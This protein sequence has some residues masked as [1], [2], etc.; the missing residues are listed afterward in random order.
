MPLLKTNG[1]DIAYDILGSGEPLL[2]IGGFG[3]TREFWGTL[4]AALA[5]RF[6][7][8]VYD[9]RGSGESTLP[10]E[11]FSI[12]DM[13]EDAAGIMDFLDIDSA[14][15]FGVS[16]GGMIAQMLCARHPDR[17]RKAILGC[18]SHGGRHAIPA[19]PLT[20]KAFEAVA[21]PGLTVEAS[22]RMLVPILFSDRFVESEKERVESY[23]RVSVEHAL[24]RQCAIFQMEALMGFDAEGLLEQIR[25]P[26]LVV[27]GSEDR[28]IPPENSR[29]LAGKIPNARLE[30]ISDAGHNFFFETPETVRSLIE[31]FLAGLTLIDSMA[32]S[33]NASLTTP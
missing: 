1:I 12:A 20:V 10:A 11:P 6:R 21:N 29:L 22:A 7:V 33:P 17:V 4:P 8:I 28:L 5:E 30:V 13:A 16:M 27:T 2:L 9:N 3:M 24:T 32:N 25:V 23:I 26:V 15:V 14:H 19:P 18:T 31:E